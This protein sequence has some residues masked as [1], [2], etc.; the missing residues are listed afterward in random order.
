MTESNDTVYDTNFG[1]GRVKEIR[2]DYYGNPYSSSIDYGYNGQD[3]NRG[4][5][6]NSDIV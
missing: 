4:F 6:R 3:Q 2:L 1:T 5:I